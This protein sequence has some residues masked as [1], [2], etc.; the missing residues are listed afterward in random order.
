MSS[1]TQPAPSKGL[2]QVLKSV[3]LAGSAA[4]ITVTFVHPIDVVKTRLQVSGTAGARNYKELGVIGTVTTVAKEE[5]ITAFWK[6]IPAAWLREASY[7]SLR[8]GLYAPIKTGIGADKPNSGFFIKFAAGCLAGGIGSI[9]GNPFDVLKTKMM[10]SEGAGISFSSTA[11]Q[12]MS[13]QGIGGFYKGIDANIARAMVNNGTKMACY[14]VTKTTIKKNTGITGVPLTVA[15][16]MVAGVAMTATVA[17]FDMV[18]T[19]LMNQPV[20]EAKLYANFGD[21]LVKII[22][23]QGVSAL[24]AGSIPMWSRIAP[25]ST[26]Q[27]VLFEGL[28]KLTGG[29]GI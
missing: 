20:G 5:G 22:R 29:K 26:L 3:G 23:T 6:G 9:A 15:S 24:W 13:N 18:R 8:L 14:D 4:V 21:C 17:P 25:T 27:F 11:K 28:T 2:G 7:T 16:A 10:A 1:P 19:R 12:I